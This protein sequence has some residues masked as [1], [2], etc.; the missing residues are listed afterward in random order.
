MNKNREKEKEIEKE[1]TS[2]SEQAIDKKEVD[3]RDI[4]HQFRNK[5]NHHQPRD[6]A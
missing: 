6:T 2:I 3:G 5:K 4:N 1:N